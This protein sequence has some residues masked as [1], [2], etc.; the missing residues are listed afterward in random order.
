[1]AQASDSTGISSALDETLAD[2]SKNQSHIRQLYDKLDDIVFSLYGISDITRA[3][4]DETLDDR[5]P[6]ILW[7]QMARKTT[8]QKRMEHVWRLLRGFPC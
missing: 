5:P 3:V 1:M 6:E 7:P 2:E 8:E 4:I